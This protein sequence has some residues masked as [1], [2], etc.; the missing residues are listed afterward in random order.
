MKRILTLT[1]LIFCLFVLNAQ[2]NYFFV[3]LKTNPDKEVLPEAEVEAIQSAHLKNIERLW[4]EGKLPVA[5]PFEGGGGLFIFNTE[6]IEEAKELL[7]TDPAVKAGRFKLEIYPFEIYYGS[8]CGVGEE[9]EMLGRMF[10][11]LKIDGDGK[12]APDEIDRLICKTFEQFSTTHSR[13]L[14]ASFGGENG[15]IWILHGES[16]PVIQLLESSNEIKEA[17]ISYELKT[18]WIAEGIF[19]E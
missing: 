19:C 12:M 11:R 3:F 10:F 2:D 4:K 9:Y 6:T 18:L 7:E 17:G 14:G 15:G 13:I 5:G 8:I 1:I 16:E